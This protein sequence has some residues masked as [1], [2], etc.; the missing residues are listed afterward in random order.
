MGDVGSDCLLDRFEV[1]PTRE[2]DPTLS[3]RFEVDPT[4]SERECRARRLGEGHSLF[5]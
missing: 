3:D 5:Q 1:D 4:R 2:V